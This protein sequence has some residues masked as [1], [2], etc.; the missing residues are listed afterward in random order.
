MADEEVADVDVR[1]SIAAPVVLAVTL[2]VW[3]DGEVEETIELDALLPDVLK[4]E[5]PCTLAT[6]AAL[7]LEPP[8]S[9]SA[10][11]QLRSF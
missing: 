7:T 4:D 1:R 11:S 5:D 9:A 10:A 6:L 8:V 2:V 3:T